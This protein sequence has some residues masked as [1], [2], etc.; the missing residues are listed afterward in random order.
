MAK[1]SAGILLYRFRG[2]VIEVLLVH[3]GGPYWGHK[4]DGVWSIP[5][6]ETD[7]GEEL[8]AAA[9]RE[10]YEETGTE[11]DGDFLKLKPV[12]LTSGKT[13][14]AFALKGD[15]NPSEVHSNNFSI[16]WP[17][18][19]GKIQLFPEIDKAGWFDLKTASEKL[20]KSQVPF[21]TELQKVVQ[22]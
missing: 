7:P 18:S 22:Q 15:L 12:T 2:K 4:E 9:K 20:T 6:G 16:E 10:F 14:H 13:I 8:L 1:V 3:P 19:S 21:I 17:P 11:V 5:K